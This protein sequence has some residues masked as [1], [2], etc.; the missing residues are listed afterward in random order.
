M[1][2]DTHSPGEHLAALQK[3]ITA[4]IRV[5]LNQLP[6]PDAA[7]LDRICTTLDE[8]V[9]RLRHE[10]FTESRAHANARAEASY[11]ASC[12]YTLLELIGHLLEYTQ[13]IQLFSTLS[14]STLTD[15]IC[16]HIYRRLESLLNYTVVDLAAGRIDR[17]LPLPP[18]ACMLYQHM[19][20]SDLGA[21]R[22]RF[23]ALHVSPRLIDMVLQPFEDLRHE[24]YTTF[25][26]AVYLRALKQEL[27]ELAGGKQQSP[28]DGDMLALLAAHNFNAP[29]FIDY[30]HQ[31]IE[32]QLETSTSPGDRLLRLRE[33]KSLLAR[34]SYSTRL[35]WHPDPDQ[36]SVRQQIT[37]S[38]D[39]LIAAT[40]PVTRVTNAVSAPRAAPEDE[41]EEEEEAEEKEM[42]A[43]SAY[44][45][46]DFT[47][48]ISPKVLAAIANAARMLRYIFWGNDGKHI[49]EMVACIASVDGPLS[50]ETVRR[51]L[52][53]LV[54]MRQA[55]E[56][57][58]SIID[59]FDRR[60]KAKE[61]KLFH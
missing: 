55:R 39:A 25:Y 32:G 7:Q 8:C 14:R 36:P 2:H 9:A 46:N 16:K 40:A 28:G 44:S 21:L 18:A 13:P 10:M 59:F 6:S 43:D 41:E 12:Q 49:A 11:L 24:D 4:D 22:D 23:V 30:Y 61:K 29:K 27:R 3:I 35:A 19:L 17:G 54:T 42:D 53:E 60:I 5:A 51:G 26:T 50:K 1:E 15:D 34:S 20:G 45:P 52:S 38:L 31:V 37:E 47:L 48:R 33:Y 56:V 58:Q 57:L